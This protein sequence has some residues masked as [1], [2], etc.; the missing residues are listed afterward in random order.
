MVDFRVKKMFMFIISNLYKKRVGNFGKQGIPDG[1]FYISISIF[2]ATDCRLTTFK[3]GKISK[4]ILVLTCKQNNN[5]YIL[6]NT[7]RPKQ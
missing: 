2:Y 7:F 5:R 1:F 6:K 3:G 4:G